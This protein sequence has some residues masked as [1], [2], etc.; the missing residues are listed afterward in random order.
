MNQDQLISLLAQG[1]VQAV[2]VSEMLPSKGKPNL[3]PAKRVWVVTAV[4]INGSQSLLI[5]T[6]GTRREWAS[7]DR[8]SEWLKMVGVMNF[9]IQQEGAIS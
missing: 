2:Q 6:R 3:T 8:L 4:L 7:L 5:S 1:L 9:V